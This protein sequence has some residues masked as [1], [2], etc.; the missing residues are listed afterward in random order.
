MK[1]LNIFAMV[2]LFSTASVFAQSLPPKMEG[3]YITQRG[4]SHKTYIE[5]VKMDG[6]K[7]VI[8]LFVASRNCDHEVMEGTAEK[9]GGGWE[10]NATSTRCFSWVI[11]LKPV[12]GKQRLQGTF[13]NTFGNHGSIYYDW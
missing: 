12:E 4:A 6:D 11:K 13:E 8:K 9:K 1:I 5:L 2:A 10:I 7:A 3:W